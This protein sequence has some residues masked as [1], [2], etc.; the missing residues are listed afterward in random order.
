[1]SFFGVESSSLPVCS[2]CKFVLLLE[3]RKKNNNR[4][5]L[6]SISFYVYRVAC[7]KCFQFLPFS[8]VNFV[9][10]VSQYFPAVT[11]FNMRKEFAGRLP[12]SV[13]PI[14]FNFFCLYVWLVKTIFMVFFDE[15]EITM[16]RASANMRDRYYQPKASSIMKTKT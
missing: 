15:N 7:L 5:D 9:E 6:F 12:F 10:R 16:T 14:F 4:R 11:L 8:E 1:M 13:P 2:R 3:K